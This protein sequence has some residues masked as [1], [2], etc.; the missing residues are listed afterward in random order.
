MKP[1]PPHACRLLRPGASELHSVLQDAGG[2]FWASIRT[3]AQ[4]Q[5]HARAGGWDSRGSRSLL[6]LHAGRQGRTLNPKP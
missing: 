4:A 2:V 5:H 1:S 3:D 6:L